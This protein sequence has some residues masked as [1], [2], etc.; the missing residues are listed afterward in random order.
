[1]SSSGETYQRARTRVGKVPIS[2]KAFQAVGA[3]TESLKGFAFGTFLLLYYN[4]ILGVGAFKASAVIAVGLI[5][6]AAFDPLIGSFSDGLKTRLGRRH[7][8][9]YLSA[10]PIGLGLY[11]SF[12]PPHGLSGNLLLAWLFG[13]VVLTNVS[14][15]LFVVPWTAL[16]A[17]FS[18]DYAERTTIVTWR[19]AVGTILIVAFTLAAYSFIFPKTA[20][21]RFGQLNPHAYAIFAPVVALATV[22]TI[23]IAT[24]LTQRD[25]PYLLQ[26]VNKTPRFSL[27]RVWR[28]IA[29]TFTNRDFLV[30]FIG[31][32]LFA[33]ID[34]TT[35]TLGIYMSTY[36]WGLG[37]E[38]LKWFTLSAAGA[39]AGFAALGVIGRLFDK[40]L[41]LL[42]SFAALCI[43]GMG[44]IG[45]RLLHLLPPNGSSFLLAILVANETLRSFLGVLLGIMFVSMLADTIDV[46]ELNTGRRQEGIFSAAL[47]FSG[48]ATAGVGAIIAGF[49]LEH[50]VHWPVHAD[51][52]TI[53]PH[54]VTR[55]GLVAGVLVPL[56]LILPFLLGT[57]YR[58][59]RE[60]HMK[61]REELD[62]R[63]RDAHLKPLDEIPLDLE[64]A[65]RPPAAEPFS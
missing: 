60:S 63:R 35:S 14:M 23:L 27:L 59:T 40:K 64:V 38:Q 32:L 34:G 18:D 31:A 49:M 19:Y 9:M 37:T 53:D 21:Y 56:L 13:S 30:L 65:F 57:R 11:L 2:T 58:V 25:I 52:R 50:V 46:Q 55:L 48:K 10:A 6:D 39:F 28:D 54:A 1:L 5:I 43:D 29:S 45:L 33:G 42:V 62:R 36:F 22:A 20:A 15:S 47:A 24:G 7:L 4:Q 41:V 12:S 61:I 3:T 26:P 8:L 51:P 44:V 17:E 16:Y